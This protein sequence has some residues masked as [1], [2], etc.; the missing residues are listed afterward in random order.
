MYFVVKS[1]KVRLVTLCAV[2]NYP[3]GVS[4]HTSTPRPTSTQGF[5]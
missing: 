5:I 1:G 2:V 4:I 3:I